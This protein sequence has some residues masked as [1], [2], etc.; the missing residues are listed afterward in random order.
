MTKR[1][2]NQ[3]QASQEQ[4]L[5]LA[6][7]PI[8][9]P[10][11]EFV[12]ME[13]NLASIGF[14]TPSTKRIRN[15]KKKVIA[16][17][18]E[19]GGR[20]IE[21]SATILPSAE[22]GLPL[23]A[24]QDTY[25]AILKLAGDMLRVQGRVENPIAFTTAQILRIQGK[26]CV[27]GYHYK[28]LHEQLLRMKTATI[29]SE[30]AVYFA[31]RRT[32]ARDAF[33]LFDRIVLF[34]TNLEDGSLAD[35]HYVWLSEW[36]LENINHRHL[37][38][39]DYDTYRQLKNHIAKALVPLMQ[40]WMYASRRTGAFEKRYDEICQILHV[41]KYE[42]ASKI[43][44]KLGPS[45]EELQKHGYLAGWRVETMAD[46][47]A[48]K[49]VFEHGERFLPEKGRAG[50]ISPMDPEV[51]AALVER[52]INRDKAERLLAACPPEQPIVAELQWGDYLLSRT[53]NKVYNPAGFY[54]HL[55]QQRVMPPARFLPQSTAPQQRE[56]PLDLKSQADPVP[57][58]TERQTRYQE[59]RHAEVDR[60]LAQPDG[61]AHYR[62]LLEAKHRDIR[63]QYKSSA[64]WSE[65]NLREVVEAAAR[66]ELAAS[67]S[68]LDFETFSSELSART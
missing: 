55:I 19:E 67:L 10:T 31:G 68:I 56:L 43:R 44:E 8:P 62:E 59:Y 45:L 7:E 39:I 23:T 65:D 52:G 32:W 42:H 57:D 9:P 13:K 21:G 27:S 46:R 60:Y 24:D 34:G 17:T 22:Y 11:P 18:R 50:E 5:P 66:A 6:V 38:P 49:I 29:V 54:V 64:Y 37:L 1:K 58:L 28:E 20:K 40:I 25:L 47:K 15:E 48:F 30:G 61:E 33:S 2:P 51:L 14:F 53:P 4:S 26:S 3:Q 36:Q 12:R 35:K 41:R 63:Q 16:R